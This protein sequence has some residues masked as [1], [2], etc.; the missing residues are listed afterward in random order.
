MHYCILARIVDSQEQPDESITNIDLAE[1]I[2]NYNNV[3]SRNV[4]LM[5]VEN[6]GNSLYIPGGVDITNPRP[7]ENSGPYTLTCL[8]DGEDDDWEHMA[9]VRLTFDSQ[10]MN[11]QPYMTW[12]NCYP[13]NNQYGSFYLEDGAL[14]EEIYFGANDNNQYNIMLSIEDLHY[15]GYLP[16]F[17]IYLVLRNENG[18]VVN[19]EK[20]EFRHNYPDLANIIRRPTYTE[21]PE[22]EIEQQPL[23]QEEALSIDVYNAQGMHLM[24]CDNCNVHSLNL[25]EGIYIYRV[26]GENKSYTI[27]FIK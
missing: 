20:F 9:S 4:I 27:K 22:N 18:F 1:F 16:A 7:G 26:Q 8:I 13:I 19:G 24:H 6:D 5:A 17:T 12:S 10:F 2:F 11:S 23:I 14:F 15:E 21:E 3:V 25:P